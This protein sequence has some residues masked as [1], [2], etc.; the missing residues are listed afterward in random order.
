MSPKKPASLFLLRVLGIVLVAVVVLLVPDVGPNRYW[1]VAALLG[2]H[3]PLAL[4]AHA[5][6]PNSALGWLEP[7]VD[8]IVCVAL[9]HLVPEFWHTGLVIA[10]MVSLA[11]SLNSTMGSHRFYVLLGVI[12][13]I[14]YSFSGYVHDVPRWGVSMLAITA[15]L[16]AVMSYAYIQGR[17][18]DILRQRAQALTTLNQIAGGVAHDFNNILTGVLGHAELALGKLE[19][20][21]PRRES[22]DEVING[23]HRASLLSGQL[24]AFSRHSIRNEDQLD[25]ANE[26]RIIT[27]LLK[28]AVAKGVTLSLHAADDLPKVKGDQGQ[29]Q[30]VIMNVILNAAE[31]SDQVPSEVSINAFRDPSAPQDLVLEIKDHGKGIAAANL[32]KIFDPLFT[33]KVRGHGLGLASAQRIVKAH[34]GSINVQSEMDMGTV[35]TIVLPGSRDAAEVSPTEA[36]PE[37]LSDKQVLVIDDDPAVRA[38][39]EEMLRILGRKALLAE[40][41]SAGLALL[42]EHHAAIDSVI[43]DLNMP[44]MDGWECLD[45]IRESHADLPVLICS[46]YDPGQQLLSGTRDNVEFLQKPFTLAKM[47]LALGE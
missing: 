24:L 34:G 21:D 8:L 43:L 29:L 3:V 11:P 27:S 23:A 18:A 37:Q 1:L 44:G 45:R 31:A 16:P 6:L 2:I 35:V 32:Q 39:I 40:G 30:Q 46:G 38:V 28:P 42:E 22:L 41:G 4:G 12:L 7:L 15:V 17:R 33:T 10:L 13:V 20:G 9:I 14:G 5:A 36:P 26:L 47:R 25:L 19:K